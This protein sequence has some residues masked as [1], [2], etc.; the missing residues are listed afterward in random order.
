M[1]G[2][3]SGN[4]ALQTHHTHVTIRRRNTVSAEHSVLLLLLVG[5]VRSSGMP[6][7][8]IGSLNRKLLTPNF[9]TY[10]LS[11]S[12]IFELA[13]EIKVPGGGTRAT[14]AQVGGG[15]DFAN[16]AFRVNFNDLQ[17]DR[18]LPRERFYIV[19]KDGRLLLL[20]LRG[21]DEEDDGTSST[22]EPA[23]TIESLHEVH[24]PLQQGEIV[25]VCGCGQIIM[26]CRHYGALTILRRAPAPVC[27]T[28]V[29]GKN[30]LKTAAPSP[31]CVMPTQRSILWCNSITSIK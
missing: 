31:H 18:V 16:T 24:P 21:D 19:S 25:S 1:I 30:F 9:H 22:A 26:M 23:L 2:N 12:P 13:Q 10:K 28:S 11:S 14:N 4:K 6:A 15:I 20:S 29:I 3:L 27:T 5:L 8:I 17:P 7:R